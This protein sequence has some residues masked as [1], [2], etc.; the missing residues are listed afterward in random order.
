[1]AGAF[2]EAMARAL[3]VKLEELGPLSLQSTKMV[4]MNAQCAVFAE[5]ELV[6][7]V[8]AKTAKPDMAKAIH[9]AV[10]DRITSL[11]RR[12]GLETPVMLIGGLARNIGFYTSLKNMLE[13]DILVPEDP[14][15]VGAFGA[16]LVAA[17]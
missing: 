13:T 6:T 11:V 17:Q 15:I 9:N 2:I 14:D 1:G 5:S 16:A 7:L 3:E 10:S 12:I 8:H 4:N